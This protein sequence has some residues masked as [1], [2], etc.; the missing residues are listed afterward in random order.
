MAQLRLTVEQAL[1]RPVRLSAFPWWVM[2]LLSPFWELARE[3]AEMRYLWNI[4]H[5]LSGTKLARLL[6]DFRATDLRTV[7]LAGLPADIHP[8][9]VVRTGSQPVRA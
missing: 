5:T 6:P 2:R 4:S 9:Q 8:D 7:M 1:G 3:L